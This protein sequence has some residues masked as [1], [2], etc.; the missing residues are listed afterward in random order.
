MILFK[1]NL[2]VDDISRV[3]IYSQA[4]TYIWLYFPD[5]YQPFF[6]ADSSAAHVPIN[7]TLCYNL[8]SLVS[9]AKKG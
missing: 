1:C 3:Y 6:V 8:L 5:V 4:N 2:V 7:S 9:L